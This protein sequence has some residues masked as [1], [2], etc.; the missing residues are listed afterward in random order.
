MVK[1]FTF[2]L[3]GLLRKLKLSVVSVNCMVLQVASGSFGEAGRI[4][5]NYRMLRV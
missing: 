4:L 1:Q 5:C 2:G 3:C